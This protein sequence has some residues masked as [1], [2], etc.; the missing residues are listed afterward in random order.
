MTAFQADDEGSI[1]LSR[2]NNSM[3]MPILIRYV[4]TK[5]LVKALNVYTD[6]TCL[7]ST[8]KENTMKLLTAIVASAFAVTAFA[9]APAPAKKDEKK[10]APAAA[11]AKDA[12]KPAA[13]KSDAKPADK[14]AEAAKK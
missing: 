14:K 13:P 12:A 1:P 3:S 4:S 7:C 2:S 10:A 11:P 9:Q 5:H 8:K 6:N